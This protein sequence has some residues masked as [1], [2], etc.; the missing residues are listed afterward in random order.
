MSSIPLTPATSRQFTPHAAL[1]DELGLP[2]DRFGVDTSSFARTHDGRYLVGVVGRQLAVLFADSGEVAWWIP[3]PGHGVPAGGVTML[4]DDVAVLVVGVDLVGIALG[5]GAQVFFYLGVGPRLTVVRAVPDDPRCLYLGGSRNLAQRIDPYTHDLRW[6]LLASDPAWGDARDATVSDL[7]VSDD[8]RWLLTVRTDACHLWDT[9]TRQRVRSFWAMGDVIAIAKLVPGGRVFF[10]TAHGRMHLVD[11]ATGDTLAERQLEP[12]LRVHRPIVSSPDGSR[13]AFAGDDCALHE[14]DLATL[15]PRRRARGT[16]LLRD[17]L[18]DGDGWLALTYGGRVQRIGAHDE[19][20]PAAAALFRGPANAL[21]LTD[22]TIV[23]ARWGGGVE[24]VSLAERAATVALRGKTVRALAPNGRWALLP[25]HRAEL[26][27][28]AEEPCVRGKEMA[29]DATGRW[30][31]A[32]TGVVTFGPPE[33]SWSVPRLGEVYRVH[34]SPDGE[35]AF[36]LHARSKLLLVDRAAGVIAEGKLPVAGPMVALDGERLAVWDHRAALTVYDAVAGAV[37][38]KAKAPRRGQAVSFA[39][40]A[41]HPAT[42]WLLGGAGDGTAGLIEVATGAVR[43]WWI[44][45]VGAVRAVAFS[46]DGARVA[47]SADDAFVRTWE[48][49][50]LLGSR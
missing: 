48:V 2:R 20:A 5:N 9:H 1:R 7:S 22:D 31:A 15:T 46:P 11:L 24:T 3:L 39:H 34:L 12:G 10:V 25:G 38:L 36:V 6:D 43:A 16:E 35:R 29:L 21:R 41:A 42:G 27:T 30:V 37:V 26:A 4:R 45:G 40:L 17:L 44:V 32:T 8:G 49:A 18:P 19:E 50:A 14:V 23:V 13:V 47:T 28:G 33:R